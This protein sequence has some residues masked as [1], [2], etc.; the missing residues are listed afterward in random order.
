MSW[1]EIRIKDIGRVITGTTPPT[2]EKKYFNGKYPFIKP[3]DLKKDERIPTFTEMTISDEG[4][5][6]LS[7]NLLPRHTPCVVT[8][9]TIGKLCFTDRPSFTNQQINS[10]IP[11]QS[12]FDN[13][14]IY[15]LL[16][17][18]IPSVKVLNGGSASGRENVKKSSF[19]NI[20]VKVP[21]LHTQKKISSILS[22]YDELIENN[23]KRIRLLE[24]IAEEIY[25]E[26]FVRL[27]FP[28]Y[29]NTK[30]VDG[31]PV[32]WEKVKLDD[33]IKFEKGIEPGSDNYSTEK[34]DNN[35]LPFLRV[36]DLG[37]RDNSIFVHKDLL[38]GKILSKNDIA[39]TLDGS[40]GLVAMNLS[41][42]FSSGIRKIV[43]KNNRIKRAFTYQTLLSK[44]IQGIIK[45]HAAGTT[46]LHASGSINYMII[47]LPDEIILSKFEEIVNPMLNE[48]LLLKD[49]NQLLQQT[50][51]LLLPRLISGKLSVEHLLG[52]ENV[53]LMAAEPKSEYK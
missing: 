2:A 37:S 17:M 39:I 30:V 36:G 10:V 27:R 13:H 14:F 19:S 40:V 12:L 28:S 22:L 44:N 11:N 47:S 25:I 8:I 52:G 29:K 51:D 5:N 38:K 6:Y 4:L 42:G 33:Y 16:K 43:Y 34:R 9:G 18:H 45:A 23:K 3:S 20:K 46:I 32:G 24:E 31:L 41:G 15:Y 21:D 1:K 53:V 48:I 35:Y 7:N 50:S 49:K 26:W